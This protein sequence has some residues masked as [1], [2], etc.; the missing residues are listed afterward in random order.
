LAGLVFDS[1]GFAQ[2]SRPGRNDPCPCGS[3]RK[4]KHCCLGKVRGQTPK[5]PQRLQEA[6]DLHR[7]G[8]LAQAEASYRRVLAGAPDDPDVLYPLGQLYN[9]AGRCD[10]AVACLRRVI[11]ARP[12]HARA[13]N[14]LGMALDEL[15]HADE[16]LDCYRNAVRLDPRGYEAHYN[17]GSALLNPGRIDEAVVELERAIAIDPARGLAQMTLGQAMIRRGEVAR[18]LPLLEQAIARMPDR[19]LAHDLYLFALN[20]LFDDPATL[21]NA[22]RAY[23]ERVEVQLR[24]S[25]PVHRNDPDPERRLRIG[26]VS[27]DFREHSVATFIEPVLAHHDR[28]RFEVYAYYAAPLQDAVT[29]RIAASVDRWTPCDALDDTQL[30]ARIEVDGIDILIDLAGHTTGNRLPAFAHKPAPV[31]VTWLGYPAT[32]GLGAIDWRL[33]TAETDPPGAETWHT[34]GLWRLPR[35]LW[36]YR[37]DPEAPPVDART[38]ARR[39]GHIRFLSANNVA[40]LSDATIATWARILGA[41]PDARLILTGIPEGAAR[42]LLH[43]RFRVRGVAPARVEIRGK[44]PKEDFRALLADT[45]IALDPYPYNGTTTSCDAL[46]S[47]LSLVT[48]A[49]RASAARSGVALLHMIGLDSLVAE[50]EDAYVDL[51]TSLARDFDRIESLRAG[52][53]ERIAGSALCDEAGLVRDLETTYRAMWH[54]WCAAQG[55]T[56]YSTETKRP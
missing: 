49:G 48:L 33:V 36:C 15:G 54:G 56:V 16:A 50:D 23:G 9:Q 13:Y 44:L 39:N 27:P 43:E 55:G 12:R 14:T 1:G 30:A 19:P 8:R 46:W 4:Y 20:Y 52:L 42:R 25:W 40:K 7:A 2:M 37:P 47:G 31:Q 24:A 6:I 18:A 26:Y 51:A 38:P 10:E 5:D 17:L 22:H 11:A 41:V 53:R 21:I 45:D 3:G 34:E 35:T 28:S 32:T 29:A